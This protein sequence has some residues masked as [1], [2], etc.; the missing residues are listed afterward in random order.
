MHAPKK[1]LQLTGHPIRTQ[2]QPTMRH[3]NHHLQVLHLRVQLG[4]AGGLGPKPV[5]EPCLG[6][7]L[8]LQ[9]HHRPLRRA[10][11]VAPRP[12][13]TIK[14]VIHRFQLRRLK[15][16]QR[17]ARCIRP[18]AG[19]HTSTTRQQQG[20]QIRHALKEAVEPV[21]RSHGPVACY[22]RHSQQTATTATTNSHLRVHLYQL[23]PNP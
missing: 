6:V 8:H 7:H 10:A 3:D 11:L 16:V 20:D 18:N 1:P 15:P 9:Q 2:Q 14:T 13:G 19:R 22:R 21:I 23:A 4:K 12:E 17:I 5:L